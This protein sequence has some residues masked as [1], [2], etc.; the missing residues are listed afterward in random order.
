[1][2]Q[3]IAQSITTNNPECHL[4]VLLIDERPE[5]VTEMAR[6]VD[7]EVVSIHLMSLQQ[8]MFRLLKW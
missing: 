7:G 3:N 2:L 6:M 4:I 8:D 1:M 5:E